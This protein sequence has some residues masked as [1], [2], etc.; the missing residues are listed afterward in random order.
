M[1]IMFVLSKN[2]FNI[3]QSMKKNI[4]TINEFFQGVLIL[5][6]FR[7]PFRKYG[8]NNSSLSIEGFR[9]DNRIAYNIIS[10]PILMVDV[11]TDIFMEEK[12]TT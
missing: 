12:D 9:K 3:N 1:L 5:M 2:R 11:S 7:D 8:S 10:D 6:S 4:L